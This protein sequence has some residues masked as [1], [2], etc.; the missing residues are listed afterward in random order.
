MRDISSTTRVTPKISSTAAT[1]AATHGAASSSAITPATEKSSSR[2]TTMFEAGSGEVLTASRTPALTLCDARAVTPPVAASSA[3]SRLAA[4]PLASRPMAAPT[5]GRI[6]VWMASQVESSQGTLS[7]TNSS[8]NIT[9]AAISTSVRWSPSGTP[10]SP[11][12]L[13]SSPSSRTVA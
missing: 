4:S 5:V 12:Y 7:A 9:A 13:P 1:A 8:T 11:A 10:S 3:D 6:T 2:L